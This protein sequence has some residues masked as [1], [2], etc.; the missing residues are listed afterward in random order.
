MHSI[1]AFW[2]LEHG[3]FL[4]HRTFLFLHV[5]QDLGLMFGPGGGLFEGE[6]GDLVLPKGSAVVARGSNGKP[7]VANSGDASTCGF[8]VNRAAY[9][10]DEKVLEKVSMDA[11]KGVAGS[12]AAVSKCVPSTGSC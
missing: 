10:S 11:P 5:V 12:I 4:S 8:V 9:W 3:C 2:Q 7:W 6:I 1:P